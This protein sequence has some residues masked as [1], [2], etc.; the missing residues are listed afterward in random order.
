MGTDNKFNLDGAKAA[1]FIES[2]EMLESIELCLLQLEKDL[3]DEESIHILFRAVH[4]IKGSSGM[5]GF[6]NIEKFT[7][8]VENVLDNVRNGNISVDTEMIGLMLESHDYIL[9]LL[10]IVE[11]DESA[12]LTESQLNVHELLIIRLNSYLTGGKELSAEE[13]K[14]SMQKEDGIN[15]ESRYWHISLRFGENAYRNGLDPRSLIR[16]LVKIGKIINI[17]PV[18]DDMPLM[19][20]ADPE[21][22]YLGFE[23]MYDSDVTKETIED[24]FEFVKED[25]EIRIIPP[26]GNISEYVTLL[27]DLSEA[28]MLLGEMLVEIGSLTE[29]ELSQVLELQKARFDEGG[30][31]QDKSLIGEIIIE[32]KMIQKP[33]VDAAL[34]KQQENK[35]IEEKK[36]QSIR[37]DS[38][39]LDSIIN[40][41]GELVITGSS[42]K[43][44]SDKSGGADLIESVLAMSSLIEEIR[45][46]TMNVRM[47]PIGDT[48]RRYERIVRDLSRE[49]GKNIQLV[50][51]G[52]ETELDRSI[53]EKISDPLMH[54]VRNAADH[55]IG[56]PQ[57]RVESGKTD[58]GTI[59][60]N[61][62]YETGSV[63]IEIVDDGRG[64]DKDRILSKAI[65]KGFITA[66]ENLSD[67]ELFQII[68]EPGFSTAEKVTNIS[69]RGVGMDVVKRNIESIRGIIDIE[70]VEGEGTNIRIRLPLTLA[71]IDGFMV[72]VNK[73]KY[74]LPLDMVSECVEVKED[75][76]DSQ[77]ASGGLMN[78]R[79]EIIPFLRMREF[80]SVQG[81]NLE[82]E[83]VVVCD[84]ARKKASIVVDRLIG[85]FQTVVK[86]LGKL[87][88]NLKWVSGATILGTGEVVLI[89]DIPMLI[90]H[91]DKVKAEA[92]V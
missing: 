75:E 84:F 55:G 73:V 74:I 83:N 21:T 37:V 1:F 38:D 54:L 46:R 47:I 65:E 39:K 20:E 57:E 14:D 10:K 48:F 88:K 40:L 92:V 86:P 79:G 69:G 51:N 59:F 82:I 87:F 72:E 7:H 9:D 35:K 60:L 34:K 62:Y 49:R 91:I 22:C 63:V 16:Y 24:I 5:F 56:T 78:L 64:I 90:S 30:E 77:S 42:V 76:L 13:S 61:A 66:D 15:V 17:V 19:E 89:L 71:I 81:D 53:I 3:S 45:D 8:V 23:I 18:Y 29:Y 2:R 41:V 58:F 26:K 43:E 68:F 50:V 85:E 31:D 33:V 25:C 28:P 4:T 12:E 44:E 11:E 52:G 67:S 6:D 36:S 70:S 27:S 32:E 80:L